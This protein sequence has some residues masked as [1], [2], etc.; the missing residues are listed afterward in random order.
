MEIY[1]LAIMTIVNSTVILNTENLLRERYQ[2]KKKEREAVS[3]SDTTDF[4]ASKFSRIKRN[5]T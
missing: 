2:I 1:V 3:I 4:T 5:I